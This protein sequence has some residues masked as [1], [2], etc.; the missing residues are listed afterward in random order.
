MKKL[1]LLALIAVTFVAARPVKSD[2]PAPQCDP[3]PWV[4]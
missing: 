1:I 2:N 3:C 4:R